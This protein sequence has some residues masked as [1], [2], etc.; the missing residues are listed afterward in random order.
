MRQGA[1]LFITSMLAF[2]LL[3]ACNASTSISPT[4]TSTATQATSTPILATSTI[5]PTETRTPTSTQVPTPTPW[6]TAT[7]LPIPPLITHTWQAGPVLIRYA[8]G[9]GDGGMPVDLAIPTILYA[10]GTIITGKLGTNYTEIMQGKLSRKEVCA[11]LN[12][13]DQTGFFKLTLEEW[14]WDSYQAQV[15]DFSIG[16]GLPVSI[17]DVQTWMTQTVAFNDLDILTDESKEKLDPV[18]D[19]YPPKAIRDV[20]ALKV[21]LQLKS[22]KRYMPDRL[23]LTV[24]SY[25]QWTEGK[26]WPKWPLSSPLSTLISSTVLYTGQLVPHAIIQ[27]PEALWLYK[28]YYQQRFI[29]DGANFNE[30]DF[31]YNVSAIPL[32]PLESFNAKASGELTIPSSDVPITT[33]TLTCYPTDGVLPIPD[34]D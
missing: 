3:G 10:D 4:P 27:G 8:S 7:P 34:E 11:L 17:I 31:A 18:K 22:L 14:R 13:I 20:K 1:S 12:T 5:L 30:D 25:G 2:A 24:T 6:P 29:Y 23:L 9:Y 15:N 33:T 32:L 28:K 19:R 26:D 16:D 21:Y